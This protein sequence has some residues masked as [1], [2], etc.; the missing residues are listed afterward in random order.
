M[1]EKMTPLKAIRVKCIDC[2]CGNTVEVKLCPVRDC[3]LYPYRMGHNPKRKGLG[4][5]GNFKR[6][7][8][9]SNDSESN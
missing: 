8:T 7:P 2:C 6:L 3:A 1:D 9:E 5:A 4:N